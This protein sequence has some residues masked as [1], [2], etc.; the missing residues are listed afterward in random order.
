[1]KKIACAKTELLR[2]AESSRKY[3]HNDGGGNDGKRRGFYSNMILS[4]RETECCCRCCSPCV[5]ITC[6]CHNDIKGYVQLSVLHC[7]RCSF[8]RRRRRRRWW[9][10]VSVCVCLFSVFF[11][12]HFLLILKCVLCCVGFHFSMFSAARIYPFFPFDFIFVFSVVIYVLTGFLSFGPHICLYVSECVRFARLLPRSLAPTHSHSVC[13]FVCA[14]W[15]EIRKMNK[16]ERNRELES[17]E[18]RENAI[19]LFIVNSRSSSNG[20]GWGSS[21]IITT[22]TNNICL[23]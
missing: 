19:F 14:I 8:H 13:R 23:W 6:Y 4:Y 7:W 3:N 20:S 10:R 16:K 2:K 11:T 1:M 18:L 17:K 15:I 5:G 12:F 9:F 22:T 21:S